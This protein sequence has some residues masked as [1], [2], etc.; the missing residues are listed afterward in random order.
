MPCQVLHDQT[1]PDP[2]R[3]FFDSVQAQLP[4]IMNRLKQEVDSDTNPHKVDL[5]V[6]VYRNEEGRIHE[7][8][9]LTEVCL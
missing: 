1:S 5:G 3:M 6:G 9:A 8:E 4:D 7:L 2:P